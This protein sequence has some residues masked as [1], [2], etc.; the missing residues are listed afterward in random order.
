MFLLPL[1]PACGGRSLAPLRR[2][3]RRSRRSCASA[4]QRRAQDA[5]A[6]L[7]VGVIH[8][9]VV[10]RR[11]G[12][13][14]RHAAAGH[15]AFLDRSAGRAQ[16]VL[17]AVLLFLQLDLG[18]RA[19]ADDGHAA[20][21]LGQPLLQLLPVIVAGAAVDL[22]PDLL[23]AAHD[24]LSSPLPPTMVV[25]SLVETTLSA[26]PRSSMRG[27][28]QLAAH[29]LGDD[30]ATGEDGDV[31]QHR[32]AA[33]AKAGGLDRQHV[34]HT[35]QL[36]QHQRRQRLAVDILGD[37]DQLALAALHQLLQDRAPG[38]WQPRSSCRGSGCRALR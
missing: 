25:S 2:P 5:D 27:A 1:L 16:R 11:D 12:V 35:A 31:A 38:R 26:R 34:E 13:D 37:D 17:D 29:L 15:D 8:L 7:L 18:R 33:V 28:L 21:Q 19:H 22:D 20:G 32:L 3:G 9:D 10:Q 23:D 36:V 24:R 14:Q 4:L 6:G 30:L